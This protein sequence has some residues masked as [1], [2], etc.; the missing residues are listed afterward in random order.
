MKGKPQPHY[1]YF[2]SNKIN[3]FLHSSYS[4]NSAMN[5]SSNGFATQSAGKCFYIPKIQNEKGQVVFHTQCNGGTIHKGQATGQKNP[6]CHLFK[7]LGLYI[8]FLVCVLHP[9]PLCTLR[10]HNFT[11]LR[12]MYKLLGVLCHK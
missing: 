4:I 2:D 11:R 3:F 1:I 5:Q 7:I 10:H 8:L 12:V 6:M 9:L